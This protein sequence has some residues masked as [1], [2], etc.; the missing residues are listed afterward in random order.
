MSMAYRERVL[1]YAILAVLIVA[2]G[3]FAGYQFLVKPLGEKSRRLADLDRERDEK[4]L[5]LLQIQKD[6]EHVRKLLPLSLPADVDTARRE[7]ADELS[8]LARD[9]GFEA[10]AFPIQPKPVDT[11][12]SP[13][14]PGKKPVY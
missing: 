11:K 1:S 5:R 8:K 12:S 7:Y 9:A 2:G 14:L 10:A 6:Q 4:E 13:Q 3:A